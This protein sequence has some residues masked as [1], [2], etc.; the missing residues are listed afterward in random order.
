MHSKMCSI[1]LDSKTLS[2]RSGNFCT[3]FLNYTQLNTQIR[4]G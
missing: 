2:A 3:L 4:L 1:K